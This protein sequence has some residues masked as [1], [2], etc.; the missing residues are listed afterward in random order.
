MLL[1]D[2]NLLV[3][4]DTTGL[5]LAISKIIVNRS[6]L[7]WLDSGAAT[8]PTAMGLPWRDFFWDREWQAVIAD[9]A[10]MA[11]WGGGGGRER[12]RKKNKKNNCVFI[13][14]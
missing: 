6:V 14:Y 9:Q 13:R 2:R 1:D 4:N 11:A 12:E 7:H 5:P 3:A 10:V 8:I